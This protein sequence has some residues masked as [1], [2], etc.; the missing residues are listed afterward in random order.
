MIIVYIF[1]NINDL[2]KKKTPQCQ[3]AKFNRKSIKEFVINAHK[4]RK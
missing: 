1:K 2:Q 4:K 3:N